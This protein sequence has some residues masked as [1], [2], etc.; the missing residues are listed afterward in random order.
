ME[1]FDKYL[2]GKME[3]E[4]RR[5]FEQKMAEDS[6]LQTELEL[7]EGLRQV[8]FQGKVNQVATLR[9][10]WQRRRFWRMLGFSGLLLGAA[11]SLLIFMLNQNK[12]ETSSEEI[13]TEL[14]Q[15]NTLDQSTKKENKT[16]QKKSERQKQTPKQKYTGPIAEANPDELTSPLY[17]SPNIRGEN[18]EN[19]AW[20]ALL[21]KIWY[22]E[23]PLANTSVSEIFKPADQLLKSRNFNDAYVSLQ[24][25][26]RNLPANDTLRLM[27]GYCLL[28]MGEGAEAL[29]VFEG[30]EA[31]HPNWNPQLEWLRGLALVISGEKEKAVAQ[32]LG[33][34]SQ[35]KHPYRLQSERAIQL[36]K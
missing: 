21:D 7:R 20:K 14:P 23:Y 9:Q 19:P 10:Q 33:I 26:E 22:T 1:E 11:I 34:A 31:Q 18:E 32:F 2:K 36:L 4:E 35:T 3:E 13:S 24:R 29:V 30:L 16:E 25:L 28:E 12:K 6:A 17:P 8:H 5:L 27:K 15:N